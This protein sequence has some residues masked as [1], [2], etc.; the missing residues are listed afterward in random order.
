MIRINEIPSFRNPD[1]IEYR[2][3][4][5][6]EKVE[7]ING[8]AVQDYGHV[9]SGDGFTLTCLFSYENYLQL[10]RLWQNR[11]KVT[12]TDEA[13]EIWTDMRLVFK[14]IKRH[15]NFPGYVMLTFEMWRV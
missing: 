12:Y 3:D 15:Q 8:N 1:S 9:A 14:S 2:F 11:E 5:R 13:G 6:I 4:D 10:E 7:L